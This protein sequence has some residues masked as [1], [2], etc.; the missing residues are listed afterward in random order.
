MSD[1][2]RFPG[3]E[4]QQVE[5]EALLTTYGVDFSSWGTGNA[6]TL[7]HLLDEIA[8]GE[9]VLVEESG[10][11]VRRTRALDITVGYV[12]SEG[13]KHV[14]VE[15][16]QE[17]TDGRVRRRAVGGVKEKLSKDEFADHR[18]VERALQ[19]ELG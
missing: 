7:Q 11:L 19:E 16:R 14:L 3:G 5:L 6:K 8:D 13:Q 9:A 17:F 2:E 1:V 4:L 15:D 12:D 10:T 18:S